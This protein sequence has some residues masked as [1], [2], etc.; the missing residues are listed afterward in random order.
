MSLV[1]NGR[2]MGLYHIKAVE[3]E[4]SE[5]RLKALPLVTNITIGADVILR[6]DTPEHPSV[7][8]FVSVVREVFK[9]HV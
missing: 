9:N 8:K 1:E 2:G 7:T 5:G 6:I 4:I 3:R